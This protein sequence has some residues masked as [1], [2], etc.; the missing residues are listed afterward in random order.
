MNGLD[1]ILVFIFIVSLYKGLRQGLVQQVVGLVSFF[2]AFYIALTFSEY[3]LNIMETYLHLNIIISSL[4]EN[5]D[6]P[7][8]LVQIILNIIA[9]L[10]AFAVVSFVLYVITRKLKL[11]NKIPL[12]GPFN[13]ISGGAFGMLKGILIVFLVVGLLS[14]IE[15]EFWM[16]ALESSVIVAL[17]YHYLTAVFHFIVGCIVE[18]LGILV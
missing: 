12:I 1:Y 8:W 9:F 3:V 15:T 17:S 5:G 4:A 2:V 14:L 13:V 10:L 11:V 6:T 7:V 16:E 18:S